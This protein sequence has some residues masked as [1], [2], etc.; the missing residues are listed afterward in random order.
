[1]ANIETEKRLNDEAFRKSQETRRR[2]I[3][4]ARKPAEKQEPDSRETKA[5]RRNSEIDP[6]SDPDGVDALDEDTIRVTSG[7]G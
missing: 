6:D 1:M 4:Q 7:R 3:D 2:E 5:L